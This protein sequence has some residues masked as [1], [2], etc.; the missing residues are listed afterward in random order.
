MTV[1]HHVI[2]YVGVQSETGGH[3]HREVREET[4]Q[5]GSQ[6]RDGGRGDD[7]VAANVGD[8]RKVGV[9]SDAEIVLGAHT[10]SSGIR[11]DAGVDGDLQ[12]YPLNFLDD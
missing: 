11:D 2:T 3:A 4:H 8:T 12:E 9:V 6:R 1:R 10:G 5:E 7:E